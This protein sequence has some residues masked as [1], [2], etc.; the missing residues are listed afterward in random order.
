M[1]QAWLHRNDCAYWSHRPQSKAVHKI[2][3]RP[4]SDHKMHSEWELGFGKCFSSLIVNSG[5]PPFPNGV[6]AY[7]PTTSTASAP[8]TRIY[9]GTK[10]VVFYKVSVRSLFILAMRA[11]TL[12][13]I[14]R[15]PISTT[16]PPRMSGLTW[17]HVSF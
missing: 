17:T 10:S 8:P 16:R 11:E 15:S 5:N 3:G 2:H 1:H 12:R 7:L 13:S 9:E 14:V 4:G 6:P